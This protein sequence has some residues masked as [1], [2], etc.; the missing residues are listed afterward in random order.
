MERYTTER[1]QPK[2]ALREEAKAN[3]LRVTLA[4]TLRTLETAEDIQRQAAEV[5]AKHFHVARVNF[6]TL[7]PHG[8]FLVVEQEYA[9]AL[10]SVV[11]R[12]PVVSYRSL[13]SEDVGRTWI[14]ENVAEDRGLSDEEKSK[15]LNWRYASILAIKL[16]TKGQA[17]G[18]LTAADIQPRAWSEAEVALIDEAAERIWTAIERAEAE[19]ALRKIEKRYRLVSRATNDVISDWDIKTDIIEWNDTVFST[20]GYTPE[21]LRSFADFIEHVFSEDREWVENRVQRV[22]AERQPNLCF[23]FRFCKLDGTLLTLCNRSYI[24][25]DALGEP[26]RMVSSLLDLTERRRVEQELHTAN[27]QLVEND[28]RKNE[29]LAM[30][31]HE[32]RNPLAV[33]HN[34]VQLLRGTV[35]GASERYMEVLQRQVRMLGSIVGDLLDASRIT[36][37]LI[38]LKHTRVN[39]VALA[40]QALESTSPPLEKKRLTTHLNLP[41]RPVIVLGDPVRLEQVLVNL[42]T[43]A[44]KYTDPGG[45]V[46]LSLVANAEWAEVRVQDTGIG[47][48]PDTRER[49]FALFGQAERGRDRAEGGLGIGLTIAKTLVELHGGRIEVHSA[50]LGKGAEFTVTLPLA[51]AKD[52]G[53][54][55]TPSFSASGSRS[56]RILVVEDNPDV[57]ETMSALLQAAGHE[58][59][60]ANNGPAAL[61]KVEEFAPDLVLLDIGLPGM[62]GYEVARRLRQNPRT[63]NILVAALTGYGQESD[64]ELT[65]A[66]G[67]DVHFV[68]PVDFEALKRFIDSGRSG[69]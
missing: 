54:A 60:A 49:I 38:T 51:R 37:G 63:R 26:E 3:R 57:A 4:D 61:K 9:P 53:K 21:E 14:V 11:G 12:H 25:Y 36:R 29:F 2:R 22:M 28:R 47:I 58:V 23:E 45:E 5:I 69:E 46:T 42:L 52:S 8:D 40:E 48:A 20:C 7:S 15:F 41:D 1:K 56:K 50:G 17:G 67:F 39:M 30:L 27:A 64:R 34:T 66:A 31:A 33:I 18:F 13:L 44:A 16:V 65:K 68:K 55:S 43:N 32:L 10:P 59:T 24:V 19:A 35:S 62:D 6:S